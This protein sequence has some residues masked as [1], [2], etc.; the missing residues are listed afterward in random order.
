[1]ATKSGNKKRRGRRE[2]KAPEAARV[3]GAETEGAQAANA[4]S[5]SFPVVGIGASAGGLEA[6][7]AI[8]HQLPPDT[9]MAFVVVQHLD[10]KHASLLPDLL[11]K[12]TRMRVREIK[13]GMRVEPDH[14]YVLP[15]NAQVEIAGGVLRLVPRAAGQGQQM[16]IDHFLRSLA[17]DMK[18]RAIGIV[19]SGNSTDGALGVQAIKAEGG[20]TFAQDE[21]SAKYDG[22]PRAAAGTGVVDF[23]LA[24]EAIAKELARIGHHPYVI[25]AE[26]T[27]ATAAEPKG[28][29]DQ[30]FRLLRSA[31]GVD[32]SQYKHT[33]I[34]RRIAR[35]MALHKL[36][37]LEDYVDL[38]TGNQREIQAL[39]Y[40]LL[41]KVTGFFRDTELFQTLQKRIYPQLVAKRSPDAP[42]RIWVPGCSTGEEA[43]S[44]AMTLL[45]FLAERNLH[46][47]VQIFGTD[48][49]DEAIEK[50]RAGIY[51]ENI[52]LD[53]SPERLRR[54]FHKHDGGYQV[55][56]SI[57]DM[58]V[59][60]RQNLAK[61][62]PFSKLDLISCRNV[63][64][65]LAPALQK[66]VLPVFHYAL[67][68][69]GFLVLGSSETITGF[70]DLFELA[71]KRHKVYK[72]R[73][74][75][76]VQR[77][78]F[79]AGFRGA[80]HDE[81]RAEHVEEGIGSL[82]LQREADRIVLAQYGPAGVIINEEFDVVQF[83][84][85]TSPYLE[86]APGKA[87][88]SL[89]KMVRE[90]LL[91]ELRSAVQKAKRTGEIVQKKGVT[92]RH[93]HGF[94]DVNLAV[95][96]LRGTQQGR[97]YLVLFEES[98]PE[99]PAR[100]EKPKKASDERQVGQLKQ[101]LVAT[102]EYLQSIIEEQEATNEEL[103]SAN[104]EVLS[105][106]EELQSI[107]EELETAKEELQSTNEELT[108][109]NEELQTRNAELSQTNDD[110]NNLLASVN[111]AIVML[112]SDLRIR[113]FTPIAGKIL[114]LIPTD[115]GRPIT[116]IRA[117]VQIP[118]LGS[119]IAEVIDTVSVRE[120]EVC[121]GEGCKWYSLAIRPYRTA[122]NRIDGAVLTLVDIDALKRTIEQSRKAEEFAQAMADAID[123]PVVVLDDELRVKQV[124]S[125]FC[126]LL[127]TSREEV[128][129]RNLEHVAP[130]L[131]GVR[132]LVAVARDNDGPV[133][134]HEIRWSNAG[135]SRTLHASAHAIRAGDSG[136]W[137]AV[138]IVGSR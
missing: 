77:F 99:P 15:P 131:G 108:T 68:P 127:Q 78:D 13:N 27:L 135:E 56:K 110:L 96:P 44:I 61:D 55:S 20:I 65:Y 42:I 47:Q 28:P 8:L 104:E 43:Y 66:R 107:N 86:P 45:E 48:V 9:G 12:A 64:I 103:Q 37:R 79:D 60:A 59:F 34:Q 33:T 133:R 22:M 90:G 52:A 40:E 129:G 57:R 94:R 85:R 134:D 23:V 35:R 70:A 7:T 115:L 16:P 124:N 123:D 76:N 128:K 29:M 84:G 87:S 93:D 49:S 53:V 67:N 36:E 75:V 26:P 97:H 31:S 73:A 83:R 137:V 117:A 82:D 63:L 118:E 132:P 14:L 98:Q 1:M 72:K 101:E 109:V 116:D 54:F 126:E 50:A 17:E 89:L 102:R 46:H 10:P 112:G 113:R 2:P 41:I 4:A 30:I 81:V 130:G 105:S 69:D 111:I 11:A 74:I 120:R 21:K 125:A 18:T 6:C 3:N 106:N 51:V 71:D 95:V 122:D 136:R 91:L 119:L 25:E 138:R 114:N 5:P 19:L 32:F 100:K 121:D 39:Y 58:C 92:T 62:P 80:R 88:L 38:L 24:P